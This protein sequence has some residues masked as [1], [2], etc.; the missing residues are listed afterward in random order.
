MGKQN[1]Q[2]EKVYRD[3]WA[4]LTEPKL[5]IHVEQIM[6]TRRMR[7]VV[8]SNAEIAP[9]TKGGKEKERLM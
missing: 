4:K 9:V 8:R 6:S 1:V 2:A 7:I 5:L 3:L